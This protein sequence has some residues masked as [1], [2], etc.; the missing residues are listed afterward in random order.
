MYLFDTLN[1]I[2]S[3][4]YMSVKMSYTYECWIVIPS[5]TN[6]SHFIIWLLSQFL[7]IY[8]SN[9]IKQILFNSLPFFPEKFFYIQSFLSGEPQLSL[10]KLFAAVHNFTQRMFLIVKKKSLNFAFAKFCEQ[11]RTTKTI[12]SK[13]MKHYI[14]CL[15]LTDLT[16]SNCQFQIAVLILYNVGTWPFCTVKHVQSELS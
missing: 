14:Q 5:K 8:L 1:F 11:I 2:K 16:Y 6:G 9:S 7:F 12:S 4:A 13:I 15:L 10:K 3:F